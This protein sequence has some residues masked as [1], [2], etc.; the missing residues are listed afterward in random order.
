MNYN[1]PM[2]D[3][4]LIL[5]HGWGMNAS[6]FRA[7]GC[8]ALGARDLLVPIALKQQIS[9]VSLRIEVESLVGAAH[10][11][12]LSRTGEFTSLL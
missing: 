8:N 7:T 9:D 5:L 11:P 2:N 6:V 12:Y 10:A 3:E 4:P 1:C